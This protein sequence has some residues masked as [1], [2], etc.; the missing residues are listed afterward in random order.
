MLSY[1]ST[2]KFKQLSP[3][4]QQIVAESFE[5][6]AASIT[7]RSCLANS[8]LFPI[9]A[10]HKCNKVPLCPSALNADMALE[11]AKYIWTSLRPRKELPGLN[12]G[13]MNVPKPLIADVPQK[14]PGQYIEMDAIA[15]LD[16]GADTGIV[17]CHFRHVQPDGKKIGD[18]AHCIVRYENKSAWT[19]EWS[20]YEHMVKNS[21]RMLQDKSK[22]GQACIMQRGL[23][24]K[25]FESFVTY[26]EQYRCMREVIFDGLEG[27][28]KVEFQ[29]SES[30]HCVPYHLDN[31]CHLSGFLCNASA[32]TGPED[33]VYVSEGWTSARYFDLSLL[34]QG[35]KSGKVLRNY[36]HMQPRAKGVLQGDVYVLL[37]A[38]VVAVWEGI[39]FK[40]LPRKVVNIF[41]PPPKI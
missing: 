24:Y 11:V 37:D 29:T 15:D 17:K 7:I 40:E 28:A 6:D 20:R 31:T 36:V 9:I 25:V 1:T 16:D 35:V 32:D 12:V 21:I 4:C 39:R 13:E 34:T 38:E 19:E 5:A 2:D 8:A 23:A 10:A 3:S 22:M 30:D 33:N 41:L 27:T 26:G 18:W 14:H